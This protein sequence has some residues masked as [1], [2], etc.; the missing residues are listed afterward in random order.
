MR[1]MTAWEETTSLAGIY[2]MLTESY[3]NEEIGFR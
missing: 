3:L 2:A 1:Q